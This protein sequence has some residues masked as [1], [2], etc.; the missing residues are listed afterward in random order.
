MSGDRGSGSNIFL[1]PRYHPL[2]HTGGP[3]FPVFLVGEEVKSGHDFEY[4]QTCSQSVCHSGFI[5]AILR[6]HTQFGSFCTPGIAVLH[7]LLQLPMSIPCM[8]C[9]TFKIELLLV[10]MLPSVRVMK[11]ER[12]L[13]ARYREARRGFL[14]RLRSYS[15]A[16]RY[17]IVWETVSENAGLEFEYGGCRKKTQLRRCRF[18]GVQRYPKYGCRWSMALILG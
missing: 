17:Q 16:V 2:R 4:S 10:H 9:T 14:L 5:G 6:L 18:K 7:Y 13:E 3:N 15:L 11:P 8:Y 1:S 12:K